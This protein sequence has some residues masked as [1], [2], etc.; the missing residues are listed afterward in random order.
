MGIISYQIKEH[1]TLYI[2]EV[3]PWNGR[4]KGELNL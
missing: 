1:L 4:V 2:A 3:L